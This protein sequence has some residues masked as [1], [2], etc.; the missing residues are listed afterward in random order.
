MSVGIVEPVD[1]PLGGLLRRAVLELAGAERRRSF[2]PVLHV[3]VP[4][5]PSTTFE[6]SYAEPLDL[7]LR[8]DTLEAMLRRLGPTPVPPLVWLT[9]PGP[10]DTQDVDLRWLSASATA[11]AELD[12]GLRMVV[13]DRRGWRDPRT[14]VG[15]EWT[16]LRATRT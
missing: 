13:V 12:V 8:V 1:E 6:A 10:L 16:R 3:G 5:G 15:R 4:G 9:R 7:A 14:L 11:A 2:P